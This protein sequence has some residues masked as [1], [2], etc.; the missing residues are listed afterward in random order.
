MLYLISLSYFL[1]ELDTIIST[2][3]IKNWGSE[4]FSQG[5][6]ALKS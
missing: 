3:Q 4:S 1:Y 2:L 6:I 5:Q